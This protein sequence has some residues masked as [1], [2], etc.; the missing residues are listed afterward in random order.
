MRYSLLRRHRVTLPQSWDFFSTAPDGE[1]S[2]IFGLNQRADWINNCLHQ[3][4]RIQKTRCQETVPRRPPSASIASRGRYSHGRGGAEYGG[5]RR[6]EG[7][8][9][10]VRL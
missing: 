4:V 5:I 2:P 7:G 10:A 9:H 8:A 6:T 3:Q 1:L